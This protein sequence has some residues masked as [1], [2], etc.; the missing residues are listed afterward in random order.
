MCLNINKAGYHTKT[1]VPAGLHTRIFNFKFSLDNCKTAL[2][3][4]K[5]IKILVS[6]KKCTYCHGWKIG[7]FSQIEKTLD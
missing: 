1:P 3:W 7:F 5:T 6:I 4:S 2:E